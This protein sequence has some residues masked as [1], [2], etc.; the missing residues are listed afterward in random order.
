MCKIKFFIL[1]LLSDLVILYF[2]IR[3][4]YMSSCFP[5]KKQSFFVNLYGVISYLYK[6]L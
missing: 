3:F 5:A 2:L 4:T 1:N 6:E